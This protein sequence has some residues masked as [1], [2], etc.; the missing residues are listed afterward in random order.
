MNIPTALAVLEDAVDQCMTENVQTSEVLAAF[1]A[2]QATITWPF[3]QFRKALAP[4]EGEFDFD[5]EG[6]R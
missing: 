3:E 5:K 1:V 4:K 6:R 2:A